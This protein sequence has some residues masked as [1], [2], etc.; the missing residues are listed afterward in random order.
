MRDKSISFAGKDIRIEEKKIGELE[1]IVAD[2]FPESKGDVSKVDI[3]KVLSGASFDLLY[4]K[5]PIIFPEVTK[6]DIKNAYMSE[7]E[8]LVEAFIDVN[9]QGIKRLV[10]PLMGLIQAGLPQK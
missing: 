6:G 9:F 4:K 8:T 7:L 1:K 2:L 10:K 3:N 5:L